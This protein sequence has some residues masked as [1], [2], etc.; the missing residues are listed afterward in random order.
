MGLTAAGVPHRAGGVD[1]AMKVLDERTDVEFAGASE[2]GQDLSLRERSAP[3]VQIAGAVK[4]NKSVSG[5]KNKM[6]L[7]FKATHVVL[8]MLCIM[9]FIT[10]IDRVNISTAASEIQKELHLSNTQLGLVF[11]AFAY[12]YLLFQVIGGW[13]GDRFGP[14]K[15]LFWCGLIW[16]ASTI[17]T[18]F[19]TSLLTLF[20][21]RVAL[22]FGEG[23]TFPTATRAMQYWTPANKRGFAQGLTHAFAR[24]GNALTPP[25]I[26]ALM[27]WLTWRGSFIVLG[28]VS[29]VWGVVW[30][31]YFRNEPKDHPSITEAELA[32]LPPRPAATRP[33]VPWGP[34]LRRMWPVT[35][36]YFCY[37]W[38]LWLYLNWLPLFFKNNYSLDIKNSALFASGVFFAGV[39]GDSLGGILSDGILKRTGNVR[40]ARLSVTVAGFAGALVSLFPIL[41]IHDITVVA[42][43]LSGGFFFAEI[44][45]RPDVVG[46]DG[47][48]P[49]IFRHGR[50]P[51]EYR[52]GIG[53]DRLAAGG[54]LRDRPD[55]QLVFAVPDV[56][57]IA[58]ARRLLRV[59]DA[60]GN[61]VRGGRRR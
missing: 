44:T 43:C 46:A 30:A 32:S 59:P 56:D 3:F 16:A 17:M 15:T 9:Y 10:Y 50:G 19:V 40:F 45:D 8:A 31:L 27:A 38:S 6:R 57:G 2:G 4:S 28:L 39:V 37:G 60:S 1:A 26:A 48:R 22:G 34:L 55:R 23:A 20:I 47:Y 41:F 42:L 35:L 5:R 54:R 24:L 29:L 51:D 53:G 7:R 49:E 13:V 52:L 14:R 33:E 36:T 58:A 61:A 12:P 25:L 11:S 21:A 18:G